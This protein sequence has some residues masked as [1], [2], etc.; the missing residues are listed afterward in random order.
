M[1]RMSLNLRPY[2]EENLRVALM[3]NPS[4]ANPTDL[5][6]MAIETVLEGGSTAEQIEKARKA[7]RKAQSQKEAQS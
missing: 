3:L 4:I 1:K 5:I 2:D 6:R 7:Y